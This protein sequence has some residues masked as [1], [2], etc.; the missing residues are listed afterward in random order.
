MARRAGA[1][2]HPWSER[3]QRHWWRERPSLLAQALRPLSWLYRALAAL[4]RLLV[5]PQ[6]LPVPVLVVGNLVVG[7]A[8][9]TPTVIALVQALR[10]R[11]WHPGV[12]SRGYGRADEA[13]R[14]VADGDG[15]AAVGDEPL[16]IRRRSGVPVWVGRDRV[17]A[18]RALRAA[19]PEV[20]LIVADD[21]LQHRRLARDAECVVFD[22]RGAGNGLLLPAGPLREPLPHRLPA[23]RL[24]LY[25][26]GA[27][28]TALPGALAQRRLAQAWPLAAWWRGQ[29][30]AAVPLQALQG[31]PLV[32][33]AGIAAPQKFFAMLDAAGLRF[34]ALPLPDHHDHATLPWPA[35]AEVVTTEKDAVKLDPARPGMARVWVL[36]LDLALP[37]EVV[38][39]LHRRLSAVPRTL[40]TQRTAR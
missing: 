38:D 22:E 2:G 31:R 33:A 14:E 30:G 24:V 26:G 29:G 13:Q 7:G 37:A 35:D 16:L 10:D 15:A 5:R 21:G 4:H 34:E 25:T 27:A 9:K 23:R 6:R 36:P 1:A 3:L 40:P 18:A 39:V 8:G 19:H 32:A 11:G 20:D 17:A 12:V 28:S